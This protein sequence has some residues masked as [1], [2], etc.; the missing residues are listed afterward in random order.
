[1][2]ALRSAFAIK[3]F[4]AVVGL[5]L[6]ILALSYFVNEFGYLQGTGFPGLADIIIIISI[7]SALLSGIALLTEL[8]N[9]LRV[10]FQRAPR[11]RKPNEVY[12]FGT[13][14]AIGLGAT[15]GSPLFILIPLNVVQYQI[16]SVGAMIIAAVLSV[17]MAQ[18]YSRN[19]V[20]IRKD[21]IESIGGPGFLKAAVGKRSFRYFVS[22]ISMAVANTALAAYSAIVFVL[23]DFQFVPGLLQSYGVT[24]LSGQALPYLIAALFV[25]WFI[26]NSIFESRFIR[27]I[28]KIQTLFTIILV[29]ILVYNSELLGNKT[30]WNLSGLFSTVNLP[31]GNLP[32]AL[33]INTAYLYLLFFG[34]QEIQ[35]MERETQESSKIPVVSW[36]KKDFT[37]VKTKYMSL[38]MIATVLTASLV[39][40]FYAL[41]VYASHPNLSQL[42]SAQIPALYLAQKELGLGAEVMMAFAF[43]I[44]TFTTFVP[45]FMAAT[46]HISS[47]AEDGFMPHSISRVSWVFV[48]I[49]IGVLSV[50]GETFLVSITDFM[51]LVSLGMISFSAIWLV[52]VRKSFFA[53]GDFLPLAVG[54]G[55]FVAAAAV[56]LFNPSVAVFGSLAVLVAYL[57]FDIFELGS[58]GIELFLGFFNLV[59]YSFL[60]FYSHGFITQN[61][62]LFKLLQIPPPSASMLSEITLVSGVLL[63]ANF[64]INTRLR[65]SRKLKTRTIRISQNER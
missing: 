34:F 51:V 4:S 5:G 59:L 65:T 16:A 60:N 52:K 13:I 22:R 38:A 31:G 44:A 25:G 30:S 48:L 10:R 55:C 17:L 27:L 46:R 11:K 41:A 64:A 62:I 57:L 33:L 49:S 1:M 56:Y 9:S 2:L 3:L 8:P 50:G 58:L 24:G 53:L 61:F 18:I 23:F 63:L 39:N 36:I 32:Y 29:A 7:L 28:G 26:L 40:I 47:L 45:S 37:I 20:T 42:E 15:L 54:L 14:F 35:A 21:N 19:Y 6:V 12:G 43:L